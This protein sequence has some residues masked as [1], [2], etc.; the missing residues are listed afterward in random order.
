ME[1]S[2]GRLRGRAISKDVT[3]VMEIFPYIIY[4]IIHDK[5]RN[6]GRLSRREGSLDVV[7]VRNDVEDYKYILIIEIFALFSVS[8]LSAL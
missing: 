3:R 7:V 5:V 2:R 1:V 8:F 6:S 4:H